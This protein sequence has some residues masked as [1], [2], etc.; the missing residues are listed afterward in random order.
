MSH[1]DQL[2]QAVRQQK[3]HQQAAAEAAADVNRLVADAYRAGN[4]YA[5]IADVLGV[6]REIVRRRLQQAGVQP[7][8]RGRVRGQAR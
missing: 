4:S 5:Q 3:Q 7:R 8:P 6:T 1:L 2:E